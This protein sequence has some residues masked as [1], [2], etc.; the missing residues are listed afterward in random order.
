MIQ[1]NKDRD[2]PVINIDYAFMNDDKDK[3][4]DKDKGMPIIVI[5]DDETKLKLARV[6]PKKGIYPYA[7]D[8]SNKDIEQMRYKNIIFNLL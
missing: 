6:V 8:R 2:I 7:V 5:Q 4:E 1:K 3:H